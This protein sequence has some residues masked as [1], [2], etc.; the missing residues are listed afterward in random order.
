MPA[1][2]ASA[3]TMSVTGERYL[4]VTRNARTS[5]KAKQSR[6]WTSSQVIQTSTVDTRPRQMVYL[7]YKGTNLEQTGSH[8]GQSHVHKVSHKWP[9]DLKAKM[10]EVV[11][12]FPRPGLLFSSRFPRLTSLFRTNRRRVSSTV[13]GERYLRVTRNT[14]T[15]GQATQ[16]RSWTSSQVI[17]TSTVDTRPRQMVYLDY[18]GTNLE[19]TGSH[20]GQSHVHKVSHKWPDD[21]KAKM[22]EVVGT[23]KR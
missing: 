18:K 7:D 1:F 10:G 2:C 6:S 5:E 4:R 3:S 13:T 17:Q 19:Q 9:D 11:Q 21:L 8:V 12:S 20:V 22:G 23:N 14:R 16:S 15:S